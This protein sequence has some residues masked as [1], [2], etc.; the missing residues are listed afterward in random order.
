MTLY[1]HKKTGA[2]LK[3]ISEW[4]DGDWRM[5][6]DSDGRLFT[7]WRE[8]I[9]LDAA[10]TKKVKSLQIKDRANKEEPRTFPPDTRLNINNAT[11]QMI[12][13]HIKGV[14]LKTAKKIKDLQMS[15]SGERFSS[16]E[17]LKTVKTV[18]WDAVMA[19]DLIR[20]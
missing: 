12:A 19:A 8:E 5:V 6:E 2:T 11:A 1:R 15:L 13:D 7:C 17:Q 20:I 18:D 4:D 16:L 10:A 9:E 14:G 3:I